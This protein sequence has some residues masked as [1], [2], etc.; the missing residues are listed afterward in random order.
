[1][2]GLGVWMIR[3]RESGEMTNILS[4]DQLSRMLLMGMNTS[5]MQYPMTPITMNPMAQLPE[6]FRNSFLSGFSHLFMNIMLSL[7][8]C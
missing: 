3:R 5:L 2:A 1:M 6:I 4:I 8:N 7:K